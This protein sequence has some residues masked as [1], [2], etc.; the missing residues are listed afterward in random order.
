VQCFEP[1]ERWLEAFGAQRG[2]AIGGHHG[3]DKHA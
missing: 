3:E 2:G 1:L